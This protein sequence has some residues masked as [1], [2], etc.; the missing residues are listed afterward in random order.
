MIP[1]AQ[2]VDA[3][4]ANCDQMLV[5]LLRSLVQSR[6]RITNRYFRHTAPQLRNKLPHSLQVP[7]SLVHL[8]SVCPQAPTLNLPSTV[9]WYVPFS[10][11]DLSLS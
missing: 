5:T 11:Q 10:A 3:C 2:Q 8:S 1:G 7:I 6:L 9:S 4:I